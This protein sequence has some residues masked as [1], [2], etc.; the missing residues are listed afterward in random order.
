MAKRKQRKITLIQIVF[1]L[2]IILGL[3]LGVS[4]WVPNILR[5]AILLLV[6][7][8]VWARSIAKRKSAQ[9]ALLVYALVLLLGIGLVVPTEARFQSLIHGVHHGAQT[10]EVDFVVQ[11]GSPVTKL[12]DIQVIGLLGDKQSAAGSLVPRQI[13]DEAKLSPKI[14]TYSDYGVLI[15]GLLSQEVDTVVLPRGYETTLSSVETLATSLDQLKTIASDSRVEE[16]ALESS[17]PD[18]LNIVLIGGD[19]PIS[20]QSTAGFNY[21]VIVVLSMNF[22][23]HSSALLS[24]PRDAYIYNTCTQKKDKITHT[25]W[26]GAACLTSTLSQFLG[27][28]LKHYALVDFKGMIQV[29][30]ALGGVT[31]DVPQVIDEQDENRDFTNMIHLEPGIQKLDGREALAFLRHRHTLEG[32]AL[33]RAENHQIFLEAMLKEVA[34]PLF[35]FRLNPLLEA[36]GS[37]VLTNLSP[38]DLST[39]YQQGLSWIRFGSLSANLPTTYILSGQGQMIYTASFG[40]KLYYYVLDKDSVRQ[41]K[42]AF[43]AVQKF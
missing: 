14:K 15:Q 8:F 2:T 32:G 20:G 37:S 26:V 36:I 10:V 29:V 19:N 12:E 5:W 7:G 43:Q 13:L 38:K 27:I 24:I 31:I 17:N 35:L 28:E 25:G 4:Q 42:E 40:G 3:A 21:D 18:L 33:A 6:V 39:Y 34:S 41:V 23:T 9:R 1:V 16:V 30:D 22:K 11:K